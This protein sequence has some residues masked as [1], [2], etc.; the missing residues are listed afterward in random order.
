MSKWS[1]ARF[2]EP[3]Q[4]KQ[5]LDFAYLALALPQ[6]NAHRQRFLHIRHMVAISLIVRQEPVNGALSHAAVM[7][8]F[9]LAARHMDHILGRTISPAAA[10]DSA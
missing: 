9:E 6:S 7:A 4:G 1:Q 10:P 3:Y 2:L 8:D 5:W